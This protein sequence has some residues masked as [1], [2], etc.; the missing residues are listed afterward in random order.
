ME[1]NAKSRARL[2]VRTAVVF[3]TIAAAVVS[4]ACSSD[5]SKEEEKRQISRSKR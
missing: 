5:S 3:G 1:A 4:A 2:L